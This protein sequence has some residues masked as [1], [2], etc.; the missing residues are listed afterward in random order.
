MEQD[1]LNLVQKMEF[2]K[3]QEISFFIS[4]FFSFLHLHFLSLLQQIMPLSLQTNYTVFFW[5]LLV[6]LPIT[7]PSSFFTWMEELLIKKPDLPYQVSLLLSELLVK[8]PQEDSTVFQAAF[9]YYTSL[10]TLK[11]E[12]GETEKQ[13]MNEDDLFLK[14]ITV[15][16]EGK[17]TR[18]EFI[19]DYDLVLP[20][21]KRQA[22]P[23]S[24]NEEIVLSWLSHHDMEYSCFS[25]SFQPISFLA[26]WKLD[27]PEF[28]KNQHLLM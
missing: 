22:T 25:S 8:Y 11:E 3:Q 17:H 7:L 2:Q 13:E 6:K 28:Q 18:Q 4:F 10:Y 1:I 5:K 12:N 23:S 15:E 20:P 14:Q 26:L 27:M 9:H 16:N 24:L 21:L 19:H